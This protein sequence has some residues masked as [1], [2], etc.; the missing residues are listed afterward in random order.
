MAALDDFVSLVALDVSDCPEPVASHAIITSA[1]EYCAR[2]AIWQATQD[3]ESV[4]PQDPT[5]DVAASDA[6]VDRVAALFVDGD[7][8]LL[9]AKSILPDDWE[10][11]TGTVKGYMYE[12][13]TIIRLYPVPPGTVT[14]KAEVV[15][16]PKARGP[17][18]QW[19]YDNETHREG[20][21]FGALARLYKMPRKPWTDP[22]SAQNM[23][24]EYEKKISRA[25]ARVHRGERMRI[26][27]M[28]V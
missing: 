22:A 7:R 5:L 6:L 4:T 24:L 16:K 28:E 17:I 21:V 25:S 20:I 1:Q 3:G 10:E 18:P 26:A 19:L 15:L 9:Y 13:E 14:V 12:T 8:V 23:T 27:P 11:D 2:S